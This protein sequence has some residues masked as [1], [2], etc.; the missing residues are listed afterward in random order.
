MRKTYILKLSNTEKVKIFYCIFISVVFIF[1]IFVPNFLHY[2]YLSLFVIGYILCN[3]FLKNKQKVS[4]VYY[5]IPISFVGLISFF[6]DTYNVYLYILFLL[7]IWFFPSKYVIS[8][9]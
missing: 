2:K 9:N 3:L 6:G 1:S 8:G 5:F 7:I 4:L